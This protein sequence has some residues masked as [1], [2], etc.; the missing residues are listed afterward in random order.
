[1]NARGGADVVYETVGGPLF[2]ACLKAARPGARVLPIGFAGGEAPRIPANRLLV[3]N[4]TAF[5]LYFGAWVR[6]H[7]EAARA[8]LETLLAWHA[9][10]RLTPHVG[11]VLALE[12]ANAGLDLLRSRQATGKVVVRIA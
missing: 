5:G 3:K 7:P 10:G 2:D 6:A 4:Q 1:M 11:R 9:L 8:S 12:E